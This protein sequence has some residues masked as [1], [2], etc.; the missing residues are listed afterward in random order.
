MLTLCL[1]D[2]AICTLWVFF[3]NLGDKCFEIFE[4]EAQHSICLGNA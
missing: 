4:I 2:G 3:C 1:C